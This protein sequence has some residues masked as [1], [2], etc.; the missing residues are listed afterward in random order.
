[1]RGQVNSCPDNKVTPRVAMHMAICTQGKLYCSLLQLNTDQ[2]VFCVFISKLVAKLTSEDRN[3]RDNSLI[4][5]DGARYQTSD[6]SIRYMKSLGLKVCISAP[7]SYA[8]API[9]YAFAYFK[10][11]NLNPDRRK[12]GKR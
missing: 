9:E 2:N 4:L 10:N 11:T 3:W 5:I 6:E 8:S 7:Y 12:T 1:M